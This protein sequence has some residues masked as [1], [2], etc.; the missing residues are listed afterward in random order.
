VWANLE[1]FEELK[2]LH[3]INAE[4]IYVYSILSG[5]EEALKMM[6]LEIKN[7]EEILEVL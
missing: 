6:G 2:A 5:V 4:G 3:D 7:Y 1:V